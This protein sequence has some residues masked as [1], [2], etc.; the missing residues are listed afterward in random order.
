MAGE[1][2]INYYEV[3]EIYP[4]ATQEEIDNAFKAALYKYHPDHN[5]ERPDWAHERTSQ[6]LEAYRILSEPLS[7]KIYNFRI[8]ATLRKKAPEIKFNIFQGGDKKKY[9][10]AVKHFEEGVQLFD[11]DKSGSLLKFQQAFGA[12][13]LSEAVYN[14]GVIYAYARGKSS[15]AMRAFKEALKI[16]NDN[17][18]YVK[19]VERYAELVKELEKH[20]K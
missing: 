13:Q 1:S 4:A 16:E 14:M 9:E 11:N 3:L 17:M 19:T 18:H 2:K 10:E 12:Y 20:T 8:F 6:A 5:P 7:R 15:E